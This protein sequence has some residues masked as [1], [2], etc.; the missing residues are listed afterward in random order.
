MEI[1][2]GPMIELI[3]ELRPQ[4]EETI[5]KLVTKIA[6]TVLIVNQAGGIVPITIPPGY[7]PKSMNIEIN[8]P[9]IFP[10]T[11]TDLLEKVRMVSSATSANLISRETGTRKLAKDFDVEDIDEELQKIAEQPILNPF[12]AF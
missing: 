1:L 6:I 4:V 12:G 2:H 8:W 11:T 3:D 9:S 10:Q 7:R 5:R